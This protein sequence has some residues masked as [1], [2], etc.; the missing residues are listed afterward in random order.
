MDKN[1]H[2]IGDLFKKALEDNEEIP[3]QKAWDGIEKKLDNNNLIS[4]KRKYDSVKKVALLLLF[5]LAGLSIYVWKTREKI[6]PKPKK[7]N[8]RFS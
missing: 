4:I 5:L 8:F 1:L 2:G 3:S 6:W 7:R